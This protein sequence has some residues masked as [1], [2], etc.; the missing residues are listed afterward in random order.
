[1]LDVFLCYATFLV[2]ALLAGLC[3]CAIYLC[4]V[5]WRLWSLVPFSECALC[6]MFWLAVIEFAI[7]FPI[8]SWPFILP[9]SL[10]SAAFGRYIVV[11][12]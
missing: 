3:N 11:Q 12:V 2:F 1:M 9:V 4:T 10:A 6:L 5:K 8:I 7:Q